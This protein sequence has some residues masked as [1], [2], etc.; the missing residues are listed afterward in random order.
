MLLGVVLKILERVERELLE[1]LGGKAA[2]MDCC[3][4]WSKSIST[5]A[6][7]HKQSVTRMNVCDYG[8]SRVARARHAL[9]S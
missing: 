9:A 6:C 3:S 7:D 8:T 2:K 1:D 5:A 4:S